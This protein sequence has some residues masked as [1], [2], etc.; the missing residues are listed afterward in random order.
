MV[1]NKREENKMKRSLQTVFL[2]FLS[3]LLM[4][5]VI[6][7]NAMAGNTGVSE[8]VDQVLETDELEISDYPLKSVYEYNDYGTG[9]LLTKYSGYSAQNIVIPAM[10]GGKTVL[11]IGDE[12]FMYHAEIKTVIIPETVEYIG[13]YAFHDC[14][15]LTEITLPDSVQVIAPIAFYGCTSLKS[16]ML[17]SGLT[18]IGVQSFAYCPALTEI[19]IPGSVT[20]IDDEAFFGCTEL[21]R[22]LIPNTV[23]TIGQAAFDDCDKLVIYGFSP[24]VAKNYANA[25][26]IPFVEIGVNCGYQTHVQNVGWQ[27][28]KEDGELSGTAGQGL[29]LEG[30]R[31]IL[32]N[33]NINVG[34]NY[35]THIQNI[36][37]QGWTHDGYPSGTTGQSLRLE[38]IRIKLAGTD[39]ANYDVYYQV[40]AQN[41]G[42][43]D[44]AKNGDSAGTA[45]M[46]LRLEAIRIVVVPAGSAAPGPTAQPYI[47]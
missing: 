41:Y 5:N 22:A 42:W 11:G 7:V 38:A 13:L 8:M 30:I 46:G 27:N 9:V 29:R 26:S 14:T 33:D 37:W 16:V 24:S 47:S 20:T 34:I 45:G 35:Q 15:G 10:L 39:A 40:H 1:H 32:N 18:E 31:I 4:T 3:M 6:S 12:A 21:A 43:L 44:W 19:T 2:F 28:W 36:G 23:T 25:N 17:G